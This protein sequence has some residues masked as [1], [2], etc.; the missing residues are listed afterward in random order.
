MTII[1]ITENKDEFIQFRSRSNVANSIA[2]FIT[3][4]VV[5]FVFADINGP[6]DMRGMSLMFLPFVAPFALAP[7]LIGLYYRAKMVKQFKVLRNIEEYFILFLCVLLVGVTS[8]P[9]IFL[10]LVFVFK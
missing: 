2:F 9:L 6:G 8:L 1:K 4:I 10:I 5:L 3:L 7:A